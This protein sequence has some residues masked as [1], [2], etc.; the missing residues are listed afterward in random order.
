MS[1]GLLSFIGPFRAERGMA[2]SLFA[3]GELLEELMDSLL[4]AAL[5]LG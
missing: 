1:I 5:G 2:R 4:A 3:P